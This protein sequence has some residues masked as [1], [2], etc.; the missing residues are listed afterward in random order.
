M[1]AGP[2]TREVVPGFL[3]AKGFCGTLGHPES[4]LVRTKLPSL[5]LNLELPLNLLDGCSATLKTKLG[6]ERANK[7]EGFANGREW[8]GK[9]VASNVPRRTPRI[10]HPHSTL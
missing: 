2:I 8:Y 10:A 7:K 4:L 1:L 6:L 5:A 9:S 3:A